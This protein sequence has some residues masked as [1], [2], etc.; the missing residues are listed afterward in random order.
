MPD[1]SWSG[2]RR[3]GGGVEL[4]QET[5]AIAGHDAAPSLPERVPRS[6]DA[7]SVFLILILAGKAAGCFQ[8][9]YS[10][11]PFSAVVFLPAIEDQ[12]SSLL[13]LRPVPLLI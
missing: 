1:T 9:N 7:G 8:G 6:N 4:R 10:Q 12:P 13:R 3:S 2:D 5:R 11:A